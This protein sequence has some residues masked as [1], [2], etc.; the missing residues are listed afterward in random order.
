MPSPLTIIHHKGNL[1]HHPY[2]PNSL[3]AIQASLATQ[4]DWIEIDIMALA[5]EDYLLVHDSELQVETTG[6]GAI[7]D[8]TIEQAQSL[9]FKKAYNKQKYCVPLLSQVVDLFQKSD[10]PTRLQIDF[11]N[12]F[13]LM[14]DEPL[15]RLLRLIDPI[16]ERVLIGSPA[17][18]QLRKMQRLAGNSLK[19]GFDIQFH[20]DYRSFMKKI[21]PQ[22]PP[23]REGAYGYHDD[24]LLSMGRIWSTADYLRDRAE[25][26]IGHVNGITTLFINH[27]TLIQCLDDGFDW[28]DFAESVGLIV[29]VWTINTNDKLAIKNARRL[30]EHGARHFISDTPLALRELLSN[31]S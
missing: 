7:G 6:K 18:W 16:R 22:Q 11:K 28:L 13:P 15:E 9:Y 2:P 4:A 17:D 19:V 12:F 5:T 20:L 26:L 24:H 8:C 10:S 25:T 21:N 14:N 30:Y 27:R 3:E 23:Y 29:A 1:D 31:S